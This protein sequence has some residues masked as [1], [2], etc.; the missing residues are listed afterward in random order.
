MDHCGHWC[1]SRLTAASNP[2]LASGAAEEAGADSF[3]VLYRILKYLFLALDAVIQKLKPF[4]FITFLT[5]AQVSAHLVWLYIWPPQPIFS[6]FSIKPI[7]PTQVY[8]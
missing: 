4:I 5:I 6:L 2:R 7:Q 1:N 8:R 3:T